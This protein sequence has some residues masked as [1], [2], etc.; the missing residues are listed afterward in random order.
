MCVCACA[1]LERSFNCHRA[2]DCWPPTVAV[3]YFNRLF[4]FIILFSLLL[5]WFARLIVMQCDACVCVCH[6]FYLF[7]STFMH[8]CMYVCVLLC[9]L[10]FKFIVL[11]LSNLLI[12]FGA[13]YQPKNI[14]DRIHGGLSWYTTSPQNIYTTQTY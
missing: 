10:N 4:W 9:I 5:L 2:H 7:L 11:I 6:G 3:C 14:N 13:L 1:C 8:T 12:F